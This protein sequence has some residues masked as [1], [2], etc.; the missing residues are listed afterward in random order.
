MPVGPLDPLVGVALQIGQRLEGL[1]QVEL[2]DD[3]HLPFG[4]AFLLRL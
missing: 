3:G 2:L 1:P 4:L